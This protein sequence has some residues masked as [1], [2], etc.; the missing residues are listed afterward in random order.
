[1][2]LAFVVFKYKPFGGMQKNLFQIARACEKK[3]HD[4][5]VFCESLTGELPDSWH[6]RRLPNKKKVIIARH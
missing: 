3:G 4:I 1:M 6:V 5:T 2:K